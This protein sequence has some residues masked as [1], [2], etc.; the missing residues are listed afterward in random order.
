MVEGMDFDAFVAD[1]KPI[2]DNVWYESCVIIKTF[3]SRSVYFYI[4]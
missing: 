3:G 1:D 4:C 2:G